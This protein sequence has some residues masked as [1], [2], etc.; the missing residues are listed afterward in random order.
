MSDDQKT[1]NAIYRVVFLQ[2]GG[3]GAHAADHLLA[4]S[5][6]R[7][8]GAS[9]TI[10]FPRMPH[11]DDPDYAV[12]KPQ[13]AQAMAQ[14][15]GNLI[16]VGHSVGAYMLLRYLTEEGAPTT[17]R[18]LFLIAPPFPGGDAAWQLP[19]FS[20]PDHF[21]TQLPP[22]LPIVLYHSPDDAIIPFAHLKLYA[23]A[24]P[25]ALVRETA[26][27]HQLNNDLALV[28]TDITLLVP[29]RAPGT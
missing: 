25:G 29:A 28:A 5:L 14:V 7:N 9:Y 10:G 11:E 2:G 26:G 1:G 27:G 19:G 15:P 18:G 6:Q 4:A 23:Q 24:I 3:P 17:L 20:L 21:G 8:L 16:L 12:W 13:I 22:D